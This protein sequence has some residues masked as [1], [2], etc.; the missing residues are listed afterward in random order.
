MEELILFQVDLQVQVVLEQEQ[1]VLLPQVQ[2]L[3]TVEVVVEVLI[4]EML[5]Q[6]VLELLIKDLRVVLGEVVL[7]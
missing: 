3:L 2:E 4:V 1:M 6:V 7:P 5:V